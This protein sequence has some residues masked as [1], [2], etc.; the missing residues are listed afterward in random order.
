[1][2]ASAA[3]VYAAWFAIV[4]GTPTVA[5]RADGYVVTTA[6]G[7]RALFNGFVTGAEGRVSDV[8]TCVLND[9]GTIGECRTLSQVIYV[10][11]PPV[12]TVG[13]TT[14]MS[15]QRWSRFVLGPF[16]TATLMTY[17]STKPI[18][19]ASAPQADRVDIGT[20]TIVVTAATEVATADVT[21]TYSDGTTEL[22]TLQLI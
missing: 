1:M 3:D 17:Q 11:S 21:I 9:D 5:K 4:S 18:V 14:T 7:R 2:P 20:E 10:L 22:V 15:A 16:R 8:T 19:S 12:V 6:S 13:Q